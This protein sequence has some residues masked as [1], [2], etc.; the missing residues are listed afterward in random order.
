MK[1]ADKMA[2][3][4]WRKNV[5][6]PG[7]SDQPLVSDIS[8]QRF[9]L[10]KGDAIE[11]ADESALTLDNDRASF[12]NSGTA[13]STG[14]AS[15]VSLEA[16]KNSVLNDRHGTIQAE[17]TGI[18]ISGQSARISNAGDIVG[19]VNGV[20]FSNGGVSSGSLSNFGTISSDSRAV[21]IGGDGVL[22][23]N[24]GRIEGTDD[25]RNGTIYTDGSADNF[26]IANYRRGE[27]D[28]G[29]GNKGAG[30]AAQIGD[31]VGDV[32]EGRIINHGEI[33]GRGQGDASSGLSGDGLRFFA[34]V[35]G[36]EQTLTTFDGNILNSGTISS[37]GESGATSAIRFSDGLAF[38]GR[39]TNTRSGVIDGENNGLYFGDAEHD[40]T[41]KNFGTIQSGSRAVNID[42]S[43]VDI[44]NFGKIL[45]ADDQRNGTIYSDGT[46]EDFSIYNGRRGVIDAGEGNNGA[47]VS[48]QIGDTENDVVDASLTNLGTI[49]GRGDASSGGQVGDGVRA[50]SGNAEQ[51]TTLRGDIVNN[52]DIFSGSSVSADGIEIQGTLFEFEG[53]VINNGSI[54]GEGF[55]V[56]VSVDKFDGDILNNSRGKIEAELNSG[57]AVNS[58]EANANVVNKGEISAESGIGIEIDSRNFNGLVENR[59]LI[60]AEEGIVVEGDDFDGILS[61]SGNIFASDVGIAVQSEGTFVGQISNFGSIEANRDGISTSSGV[62][63]DGIIVNEGSIKAGSRGVNIDGD[64][65]D[66]VNTGT[67]LGTGDQRNG[68]IYT[69]L[70]KATMVRVFRF[71]LATRLMMWLTGLSTTS[72]LFRRAA[73]R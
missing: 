65:V 15:T 49:Q 64:G 62:V 32:V 52:G 7:G 51:T 60:N 24:S 50:F 66:L 59:N 9:F 56:N 48:L 34:G 69:M 40:A 58:D 25:Q 27:I 35:S 71:R 45:G 26:T 2:N 22:I 55:G 29:E 46:A 42:G 16:N 10:K 30:I 28:A 44:H 72:A 6:I 38:D 3:N 11:V 54:E 1:E 61:N 20:N 13:S 14:D 21:N 68:V 67:I 33:S 70:V 57:I 37:E 8:G 39:I 23:R 73:E 5:V 18:E 53:D 17:D 47:G 4:S 19:D 41:V 31:G 63:L 12:K 43:D 36:E